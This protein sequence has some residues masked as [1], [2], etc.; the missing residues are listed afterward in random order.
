MTTFSVATYNIHFGGTGRVHF[1]TD[2]LRSLTADAIVLTE[3][4]DP[5][6]VEAIAQ[7]LKMD[8]VLAKGEKTSLALL[9]R[10]P[11]VLWNVF[12]PKQIKRPL[13]EVTLRVSEKLQITLY[14]MHLQPHYFRQSENHRVRTLGEYLTYIYNQQ[15]NPHLLLGD[16]NAI[17]PG[18][19]V[20]NQS[21]PLKVKLMRWWERGR[22]H[23][24]A[25]GS[26]LTAGYTDCFRTL[27]PEEDGF[28][29]PTGSPNVRLDYI[30]ADRVVS[31]RL[32]T[33]EVI[34]QPST[35]VQASDHYP[36]LAAFHTDAITEESC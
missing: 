28:T 22:L 35:V 5:H 6:V 20:G 25:I 16:F 24:D 27:H 3:A 13:L 15:A 29:I 11:I 34:T 17:A 2:I 30:F 1:I 4:S 14:G 9:T 8:Y 31:E 26:L 32:L 10:L 18:D 23:T 19:H 36:L 7:D 33:C 21:Q 12:E